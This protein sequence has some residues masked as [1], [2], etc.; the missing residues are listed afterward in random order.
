MLSNL[1]LQKLISFFTIII[2]KVFLFYFYKVLRAYKI[3]TTKPCSFWIVAF[4]LAIFIYSVRLILA[5]NI[6]V[7]LDFFNFK[8]IIVVLPNFVQHN[9][10]LI[11]N[12]LRRKKWKCLTYINW[13]VRNIL[14][15]Y[16]N[17]FKIFN[18]FRVKFD[19]LMF[20]I[21]VFGWE[22]L[23]IIIGSKFWGISLKII[24]NLFLNYDLII[25]FWEF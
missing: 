11:S 4:L 7:I 8:V 17:I 15:V 1:P 3:L 25:L 20:I 13:R 24:F 6:T 22:L 9:W 19:W 2:L 21:Y 23:L 10:I 14:C 16:R 5:H 18:L 12:I